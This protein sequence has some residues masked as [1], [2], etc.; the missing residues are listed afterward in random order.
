MMRFVVVIVGCF[1]DAGLALL[2]TFFCFVLCGARCGVDKEEEVC[3]YFIAE[4]WGSGEV[5][6]KGGIGNF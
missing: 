1:S 2:H 6:G 3:V 4:R 5:G